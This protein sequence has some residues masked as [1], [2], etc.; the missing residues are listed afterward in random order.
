[1]LDIRLIREKPDFVR[2]RLATRAGGDEAKI[3][4]VLKLDV[5]VRRT[6]TE[7][8]RLYAERNR[9]SKEIGAKRGKGEEAWSWL[10][11]STRLAAQIN[12]LEQASLAEGSELREQQL[13]LEIPNLPHESVPVGKD[14][15]RE[16][17][18]PQLGRETAINQPGRSCCARNKAKSFRSRL[19][20]KTERK[21][22][23]L[24]H[25]RRR[26]AGTCVDP[27]HARPAHARAWLLRGQPTVY[28]SAGLHD[29]HIA[30][31]EV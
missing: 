18:R 25:R 26:E 16:Q 29:W 21:R 3:D 24:F 4:D 13:L 23:Y 9:L 14:R 10:S 27:F 31:P 7:L 28:S 5:S 2:E 22:F 8:Q 15:E 6:Q 17:G 12:K 30:A 20:G 1:M 11:R 19:G